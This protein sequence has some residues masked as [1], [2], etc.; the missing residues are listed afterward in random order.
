M[1]RKNKSPKKI[2]RQLTIKGA[3]WHVVVTRTLFYQDGQELL[4]LCDPSTRT[5]FI[6]K[7]QSHR[8][9]WITFLHEA[10]HALEYE[11][12]FHLSH[13]TIEKIEDAL[14][15]FIRDNCYFI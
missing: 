15:E 14:G 8:Q 2:P 1:E 4:G 10:L 13:K 9:Q 12:S 7:S 6:N 5:I 11:Y 3:H